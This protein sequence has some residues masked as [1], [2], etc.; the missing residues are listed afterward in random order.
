MAGNTCGA[1]SD[2]IS[3]L[4]SKCLWGPVYPTGRLA[5]QIRSTDKAAPSYHKTNDG[6]TAFCV[7]RTPGVVV[8]NLSAEELGPSEASGST[9]A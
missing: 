2:W 6:K 8:L 7:V 1:G 3:S 4:P 9:G 5:V